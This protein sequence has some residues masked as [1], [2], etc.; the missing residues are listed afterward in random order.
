VVP[1][2]F[3]DTGLGPGSNADAA[4]DLAFVSAT[5]R[6]HRRSTPPVHSEPTVQS[7]RLPGELLRVTRPPL[8]PLAARSHC[9]DEA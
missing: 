6:P 4:F 3:L 5:A 2:F 9:S 1:L 7:P 8:P